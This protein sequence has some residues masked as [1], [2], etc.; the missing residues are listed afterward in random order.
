VNSAASGRHVEG[1]VL[2]ADEAPGQ[3]DHARAVQV[4]N[5]VEGRAVA[6]LKSRDEVGLAHA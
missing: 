5:R 2:V 4:D 6:G 1:F 3:T